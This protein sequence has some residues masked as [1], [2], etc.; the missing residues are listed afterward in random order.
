ML[1]GDLGAEVIK[2][3]QPGTGDYIRQMFPG[4]YYATNRNKKSVVVDMKV[5]EGKQVIYKLAKHSDVVLESFRPGVVEKLKVSYEDL[6]RIKPDIIYG[7]VTGY[8]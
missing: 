5:D 4:M 8:G 1:L 7:S 3:E 2:I 6:K